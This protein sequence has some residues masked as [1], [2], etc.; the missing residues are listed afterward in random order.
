MRWGRSGSGQLGSRIRVRDAVT[1]V[2]AVATVLVAWSMLE[3]PVAWRTFAVAGA[4]AFRGL[5]HHRVRV[6][7]PAGPPHHAHTL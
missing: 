6:R 3:E 1:G 4:L 7:E 5:D 2:P